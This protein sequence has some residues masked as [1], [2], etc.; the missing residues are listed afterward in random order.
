MHMISRVAGAIDTGRAD[1]SSRGIALAPGP[2]RRLV[3]ATAIASSL[4]VALAGIGCGS[5]SKSSTTTTTT[6]TTTAT[7]LSKP[8]FLA[9]ANAIC[10]Q[11]NQRIG[12][13]GQALGSHPSTAQIAAFATGTFVPNIQGQIDAIRALAA[14][15][16]DKAVVKTMLDVAQAN[17]NRIKS[18]P[19]LLADNTPPFAE[20]GKLAQPYG[21]TACAPSG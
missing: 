11:G 17:L 8:Q 6:A 20:F 19:L 12:P 4:L 2:P 5:S 13:A 18:D 9:Q 7:G 15:A 10:T 14:P 1:M 16:A 21:L 3:G